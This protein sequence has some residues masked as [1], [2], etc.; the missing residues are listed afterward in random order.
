MAVAGQEVT[1]SIL[2][3][4]HTVRNVWGAKCTLC[5]GRR[6]LNECVHRRAF[7]EVT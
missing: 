3:S 6:K 4:L 5:N 7:R 1:H 2:R